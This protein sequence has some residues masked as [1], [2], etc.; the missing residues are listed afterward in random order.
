[1][2]P[3]ELVYQQVTNIILPVYQQISEQAQQIITNIVENI[4]REKLREPYERYQMRKWLSQVPHGGI[5]D[6]KAVLIMYNN[7]YPEQSYFIVECIK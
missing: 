2:N 5:V 4:E 1:M 7:E 6:N 3:F